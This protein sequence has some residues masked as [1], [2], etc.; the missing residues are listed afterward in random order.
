MMP[1]TLTR[2]DITY[3][4]LTSQRNNIKTRGV[5]SPIIIKICRNTNDIYI[6]ICLNRCTE[7]RRFLR[8]LFFTAANKYSQVSLH[9]LI[10]CLQHYL[11]FLTN[12]IDF[13][14]NWNLK[15][16]NFKQLK[17]IL[18]YYRTMLFYAIRYKLYFFEIY[19]KNLSE[20]QFYVVLGSF[21][22]NFLFQF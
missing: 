7:I 21:Q 6:L 12:F 15:D 14:A 4:Y 3:T 11:I 1:K 19:Y 22:I 18:L 8:K 9:W 16:E 13:T 17:T 2:T 10:G 5:S 20:R